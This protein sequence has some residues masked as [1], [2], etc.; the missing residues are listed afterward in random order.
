MR[1]RG[2]TIR[3]RKLLSA[4]PAAPMRRWRLARCCAVSSFDHNHTIGQASIEPIG[5]RERYH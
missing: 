5:S 2:L 1:A 3:S 4:A